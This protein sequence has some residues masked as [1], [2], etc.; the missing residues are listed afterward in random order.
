MVTSPL[1]R[2]ANL[3]TPGRWFIDALE[4]VQESAGKGRTDP[5]WF[6]PSDFGHPCDAFLAFRFLGAP[7]T[8]LISARLRRIYDLGSARDLQLKRD[9]KRAGI[10]LIKKDEERS[11][12]I[13]SY[14]I[15]GELD[16]LV[17]NPVTNEIYVID[18]KTMNDK[19][20]Q[21]L[22][23]VKP[24]HH[25]QVMPYE[26]AKEV[27]NGLVLYENKN[28]QQLKAKPA[29]FMGKVFQ[30][31]IVERVERIIQGLNKGY[32][33]RMPI[34]NDSQCPFYGICSHASI[35]QLKEASGLR[36]PT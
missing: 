18:Y 4:A 17:Q 21:A 16:D 29:N 8:E 14:R 31:E 28:D 22:E 11:I 3:R 20:W 10:S 23:E 35:E 26:Y 6:H 9:A 7:S 27:Y 33:N 12:V 34:P 1:R 24:S 32:V 13:D 25:L 19:E 5:G 15:R 2:L 30:T 36:W